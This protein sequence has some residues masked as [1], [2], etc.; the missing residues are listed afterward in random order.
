MTRKTTESSSNT[1]LC[2]F[3]EI[4]WPQEFLQ[5]M[6]LVDSPGTTDDLHYREITERYQK[7]QASGFIYVINAMDSAEV[8]ERVRLLHHYI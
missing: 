1:D 2:S 7:N 4:F 5:Y 3:V 8:A 6:T